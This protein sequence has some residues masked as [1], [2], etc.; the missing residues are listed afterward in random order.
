MKLDKFSL[1]ELIGAALKAEIDSENAYSILASR[2]KN[3]LLKDRLNFLAGE[4]K[5]HQEFIRVLHKK[6]FPDEEIVVPTQTP[7]PLPSIKI[8]DEMMRISEVLSSAMHAEKA[9]HEFYKGL[10][11]R[12]AD[13][14]QIYGILLYFSSMELGHY[15]ILEI[16]RQSAEKF[17]EME[18]ILPFIHVGP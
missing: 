11:E 17:E 6:T 9:A 13:D 12:F 16:E 2:V 18:I 14:K 7:V 15:K 1:E 8:D 10:A 4:E 5:K 3:A